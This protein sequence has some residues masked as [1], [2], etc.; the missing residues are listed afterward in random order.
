MNPAVYPGNNENYPK[1]RRKGIELG[2]K[3]DLLKFKNVSFLNKLEFFTNYTY[4]EPK[5]RGGSYS[6]KDIPMVPKQQYNSGL[7]AGFKNYDI[8]L[9][10]RF[11]GDR[12]AIN[13][14]NNELSKVKSYFV[15]DSRLSYKKDFLEIYTGIN[16]IFS[17]KYSEY[18][19]KGTG[20]STKKVYYPAPER[21]F[22]L[23]A[24]YK[25]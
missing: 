24:I 3:A 16:N 13:D 2:L 7:N 17:E 9:A 21:S 11:I 15:L 12:Y 19:A 10:G 20:T 4:T 22:E 23:G 25:W 8:S 14:T 5:F 18:V 1:T 6:N